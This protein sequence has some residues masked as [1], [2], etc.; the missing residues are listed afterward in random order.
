MS[1]TVGPARPGEVV[2]LTARQVLNRYNRINLGWLWRRLKNDPRFPKPIYIADVR[3][4][5]VADLE[6]YEAGSASAFGQPA[7]RDR[8]PRQAAPQAPEAA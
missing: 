4:W 8:K 5:R 1:H 7:P 3:Y 2:Y 6:A